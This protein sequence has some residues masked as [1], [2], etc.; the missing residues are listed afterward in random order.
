[1]RKLPPLTQLSAFEAAARHLSF[2]AAAAELG[3]TPTAIS[4]Q[5][6]LL[7]GFCGR[8]LFRRLPR[9]LALTLAGEQLFP[10]VRD[11]FKTFRDTLAAVRDGSSWGELRIT[12]TNAFAAR[13]LVPRLSDWRATH[14][15]LKL[16]I[17]GTDAVLDLAAS[18]ADIAVRYAH[19]PPLDG[20]CV[21]LFRDTFRVVASPRL[22]GKSS[23]PLNPTELAKFPLIEIYWPSGDST[24]PSWRRWQTVAHRR[25][26]KVPDLASLPNLA[27]REELHAIDAVVSGQG[28]AICSDVL[29]GPELANG[30]LREVSRLRLPGYGFY[31]V[32]HANNPKT[33]SIEAFSSWA[34]KKSLAAPS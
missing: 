20:P 33:A 31:L 13:W 11:G 21:E 34:Q 22:V 1:M 17:V 3:V 30:T 6:K 26:Q 27:F 16:D 24:A 28:I 5:I 25:Y 10:A 18:E 15:G 12:A 4:H 8:P 2:K 19:K 29:V 23:T 32:H 14:P 9:P 7:E